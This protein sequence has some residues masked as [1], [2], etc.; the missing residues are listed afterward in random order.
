MKGGPERDQ[1]YYPS[2]PQSGRET[3]LMA[4]VLAHTSKAPT[5]EDGDEIWMS[6]L[7]LIHRANSC[8]E[9]IGAHSIRIDVEACWPL[10]A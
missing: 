6:L 1:R 5:E 2:M 9:L 4:A 10:L 7:G 3:R 8:M